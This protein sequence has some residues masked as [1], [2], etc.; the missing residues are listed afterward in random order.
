MVMLVDWWFV[1][2]D[3][4]C[5]DVNGMFEAWI[6][7]EPYNTIPIKSCS[8]PSGDNCISL[9]VKLDKLAL[10][11]FSCQKNAVAALPHQLFQS[12]PVHP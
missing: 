1:S 8:D 2:D 3:R 5:E 9:Q 4:F 10:L 12:S 7:G 6:A 11:G